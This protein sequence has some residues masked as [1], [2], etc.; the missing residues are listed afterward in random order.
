[1]TSHAW[2]LLTTYLL[3][4][5]LAAYPLGNYIA[6]VIEGC[7]IFPLRFGGAVES[8]LYRLCGIRN[9]EEMGWLQYT[10]SILVFNVL[11][12]LVVYS[13]QRLQF[14]LPLNPQSITNVSPDSSFN[15]AISFV[16]NTNWQGYSGESAMGYLT[17]MLGLAVQN[18]FSA[19]TGIVVDIALIRGFAR[20]TVKTIGNAWVDLTRIILYVLLPISLVYT[21]FLVSQGVIQNFSAYKDVTTLEVTTYD[22][23]SCHLSGDEDRI[24]NMIFQA[25]N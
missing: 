5:L 6:Q 1:M 13:L 2:F 24:R 10:I 20:H 4:L 17:Q 22:N 15:T 19:A 21:V 23:P 16:T 7:S 14:W 25:A 11:G 8:V 9:V 3:V 12:V 18:F